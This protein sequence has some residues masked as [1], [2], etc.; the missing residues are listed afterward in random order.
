VSVRLLEQRLRALGH[1][2]RLLILHEIK[3]RTSAS[4]TTIA[5]AIKHSVTSTS[6]HLAILYRAGIVRRTKRGLVVAYR[7]SLDHP[8]EVQSVIA[9]L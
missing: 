6:Q 4:V 7:L 1:F 9:Q 8:P 2:R 3:R 5:R